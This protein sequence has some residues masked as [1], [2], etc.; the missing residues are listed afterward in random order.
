VETLFLMLNLPKNIQKNV[1]KVL[2]EKNFLN[3]E[4]NYRVMES[5]FPQMVSWCSGIRTRGIEI[6][7]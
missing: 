5:G 7:G 4:Q 1:F 2:A 6:T 3:F